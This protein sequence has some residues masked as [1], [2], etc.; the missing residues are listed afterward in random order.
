MLTLRIA[1]WRAR[2]LL[3]A[4][5]VAALVL[6][7]A[8]LVA[9]PEAPTVAVVV[10]GRAVP[11]GTA[12]ASGDLQVVEVAAATAPDGTDDDPATWEGR[13]VVHD[14]PAGLPVVP[15]LLVGSRFAA[16]PPPGT[17]V[18]PVEVDAAALLR[19]GDRVD[20]LATACAGATAA[21]PLAT[22]ALVVEPGADGAVLVATTAAH[23][24]ALAAAAGSCP[25][26]AVLVQ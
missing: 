3:W 4:G 2:R 19:P 13:R 18:V 24:R 9:A 16:D 6:V 5:G 21:E 7:A 15:E 8:R 11:A 14:V 26:A 22:D 17:V 23:A 20:L 10:V 12:L 25:V 1:C